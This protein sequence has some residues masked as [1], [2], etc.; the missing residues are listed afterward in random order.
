MIAVGLFLL[1][2]HLGGFL[3]KF[4]KIRPFFIY[5]GSISY[6]IF[7]LQHVVMGQVLG[8][9]SK[10]SL[11]VFQEC[12]ILVATMLLI[13]LFADIATRLNQILINSRWFKKIQKRIAG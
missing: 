9:F 3:M 10:Q 7:L 12:V 8:L 2:Y 4:E 11:T 6:G 5:T 13:Y 1:F